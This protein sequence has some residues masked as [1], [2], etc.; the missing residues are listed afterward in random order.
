MPGAASNAWRMESDPPDVLCTCTPVRMVER[1]DDQEEDQAREAQRHEG[2]PAVAHP[3]P[4]SSEGYGNG[5]YRDDET[6]LAPGG[7]ADG[8]LGQEQDCQGY[9][10]TR[11]ALPVNPQAAAATA[12]GAQ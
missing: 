12:S 1:D 8:D 11:Y 2:H 9:P 5:Q 3:L 10:G 6:L 7:C 4:G